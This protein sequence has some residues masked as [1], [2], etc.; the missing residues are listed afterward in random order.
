MYEFPDM[1]RS[2]GSDHV[3]ESAHAIS[4]SV[5]VDRASVEDKEW[6]KSCSSSKKSEESGAKSCSCSKKTERSF[7][8]TLCAP[9]DW[10]C[11]CEMSR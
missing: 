9:E 5:I 10:D 2:R 1:L 11:G 6:R 7:E 8:S 3:K 4:S